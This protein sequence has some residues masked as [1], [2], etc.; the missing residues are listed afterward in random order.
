MESISKKLLLKIE[1]SYSIAVGR[2]SSTKSGL[3]LSDF[4]ESLRIIDTNLDDEQAAQLEKDILPPFFLFYEVKPDA[5]LAKPNAQVV[6]ED[7]NVQGTGNTETREQIQSASI[8][9]GNVQVATSNNNNANNTTS[10]KQED[11][12]EYYLEKKWK[13]NSHSL[14]FKLKMKKKIK[15]Y[16]IKLVTWHIGLVLVNIIHLKML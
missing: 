11:M 2:G 9:T 5:K 14:L 8:S 15:H 3:H 10:N 13:I 12:E 4:Y 7:A 6:V 16:G 1:K